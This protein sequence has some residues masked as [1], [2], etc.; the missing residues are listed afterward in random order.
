MD[1]LALLPYALAAAGGRVDGHDVTA[2]VAA[3]VTLLQ[4]S[5]P[6]VRALAGRR[7]AVLLPPGAAW[8]VAL[9]ASDGRAMVV[10][11]PRDAAA[12][13]TT[14]APP[15]PTLIATLRAHDI[16]AVFTNRALLPLLPP[17][18]PYVL[19][20]DAPRRGRVCANGRDSDVDLGTHF[21][22]DLIGDTNGEGSP[23]ECLRMARNGAVLTHADILGAGRRA[24]HELRLTPVHRTA[25]PAVPASREQFAHDVVAPLLVGGAVETGGPA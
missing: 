9:A 22:L 4:R 15:E 1:P 7:S 14:G 13:G 19:L 20:D 5:A 6:L 2:L 21:A 12:S 8:L 16:G 23:E 10:L 11:D 25:W 17:D 18:V 3:G 24:M